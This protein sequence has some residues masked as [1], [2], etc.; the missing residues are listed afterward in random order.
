MVPFNNQIQIEKQRIYNSIGYDDDYHPSA[1]IASVVDD[2]IENYHDLLSP[3]YTY[4]IRDI[5]SIDGK[6]IDLGDS[7]VL[8]SKI[9]AT[10]LERCRKVAVFACTIG[11]YLEDLVAHLAENGLIV[12]AT[13]L[14]AI[15]S[16]T[17][18]KLAASAEDRIRAIAAVDGMVISWRFSPGYCDWKLS[19]QRMVFGA[20]GEDTAGIQLTKSMLMLP[21]KSVSGIIGIG[22]P[23]KDIEQ[24]NPCRTC[25]KK[26]CPGRR[27]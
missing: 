25:R 3:S 10:L 6:R 15:G 23:G 9:I 12:Q 17:A 14:D 22:L 5:E 16:G 1:R 2:Y 11:S 13:V 7:I 18:E 8:E 27:R 19:Q 24:Y 4:K 20:L 26:D 21:R